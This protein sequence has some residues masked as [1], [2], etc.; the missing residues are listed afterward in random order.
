MNGKIKNA[1]EGIL[2]QFKSGDIPAAIALSSFPDVDIPAA[3]WSLLNRTLMYI[4]G[5][6][7]ARGYRQWQAVNRYVKQGAKAIAILAPRFIKQ[8][9][10]DSEDLI[11]KGF[12]AV[13][14]FRVEDTDGE[15]LEYEKMELPELPLREV[16]QKWGI[17]VRAISGKYNYYGRYLSDRK[18]IELASEDE[19]VFFHELAHAG[20]QKIREMISGQDPV[21]EI[22]AELCA[23][24][25]CQ[26]VGKTS[27][28]L[29]NSYRYIEKYAQ[30]LEISPLT[31]CLQVLGEVEQVL[32]L[33][34]SPA[35]EEGGAY[36]KLDM[37][38][39]ADS[40]A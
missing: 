4:A 6:K 13:P 31:A 37:F 9:N 14:V 17:S 16:A 24:T 38:N 35:K 33:I 5:T 10:G 26:I 27:R 25:L 3:H 19:S 7:D 11:L 34:L 8:P 1:L 32:N 2:E 30:Q 39:S 28:Y 12:L 29:G 18:I 20:H 22:V 15:P 40:S 21:Q 23:E 36:G